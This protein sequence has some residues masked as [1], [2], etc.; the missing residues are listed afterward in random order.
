[1]TLSTHNSLF[2]NRLTV[3]DFFTTSSIYYSIFKIERT[4]SKAVRRRIN[5]YSN[6]FFGSNK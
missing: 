4:K 2:Q 3:V 1:M 5:N 6:K